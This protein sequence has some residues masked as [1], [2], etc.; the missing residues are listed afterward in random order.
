MTAKPRSFL[1]ALSVLLGASILGSSVSAAPQEA[2]TMSETWGPWMQV[3][4]RMH[5]ALVHFP[6]G[7]LMAAG[8]I[9]L[10]RV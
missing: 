6:I 5:F 9:E 10:C 7:L 3:Y 1:I 2:L 4:G 8:I